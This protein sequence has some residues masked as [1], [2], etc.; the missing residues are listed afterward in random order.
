VSDIPK[1]IP[2]F[3]RSGAP[4]RTERAPVVQ[5]PIV[6]R[7]RTSCARCTSTLRRSQC[8]VHSSRPCRHIVAFGRIPPLS[9][10]QLPGASKAPTPPGCEA[11]ELHRGGYNSP[12]S[13]LGSRAVQAVVQL[14]AGGYG[15][16]VCPCECA[17]TCARVWMCGRSCVDDSVS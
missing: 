15:Y 2:S 3:A 4:L 6:V 8:R 17:P 7:H 12:S 13:A 1:L 5:T 11:P 10:E 9:V 14:L 16:P